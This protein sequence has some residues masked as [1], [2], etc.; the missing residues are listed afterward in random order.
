MHCPHQP[1]QTVHIARFVDLSCP[2]FS[3]R[4]KP[5]S[6]PFLM[7]FL[8]FVTLPVPSSANMRVPMV[9]QHHHHNWDRI[10]VQ[11]RQTGDLEAIQHPFE[12][13]LGTRTPK[14]L[15]SDWGCPLRGFGLQFLKPLRNCW[16]QMVGK[17]IA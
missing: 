17:I 7:I 3:Q 10:W 15:G 12:I 2:Y 14:I 16:A 8:G 6:K 9:R 4:R 13:K 5:S 11:T 1:L